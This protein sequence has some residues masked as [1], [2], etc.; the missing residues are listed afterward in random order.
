VTA[1][2]FCSVSTIG[3]WTRRFEV[4]GVDA[5]LGRGIIGADVQE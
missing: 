3:R 1:S 2:L 4:E 5:V